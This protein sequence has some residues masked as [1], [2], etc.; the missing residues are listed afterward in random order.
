MFRQHRDVLK[1]ILLRH[2]SIEIGITCGDYTLPQVLIWSDARVAR[3]E[4]NNKV[5]STS[6]ADHA[7][8]IFSF[9]HF[10]YKMNE[11]C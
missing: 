4:H 6:G 1:T 5:S 2:K 9:K 11:V 7:C 3:L 8:K 10:T